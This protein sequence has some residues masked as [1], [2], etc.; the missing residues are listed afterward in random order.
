MSWLSSATGI[1]ISPHGVKIEPLKALGTALTV[2]SLGGLGGI[3]AALGKVPGLARVGGAIGTAAK[4]IPGAQAATG[5]LGGALSHVPGASQVGNTLLHG[6]GSA[7]AIGG[8]A[9]GAQQAA[10]AGSQAPSQAVFDAATEGGVEGAA[11]GAGGGSGWLGQLGNFLGKPGVLQAGADIAGGLMQGQAAAAQN[12]QQA[13][14]FNRVQ[15]FNEANNAMAMQRQQAAGP[16]RDQALF[17]LKQRM[18]A[19]QQAFI[20]HDI[21]NQSYGSGPAQLGG[22]SLQN[23]NILN[24]AQGHYQ[25]GMGGVNQALYDAYMKK[26]GSMS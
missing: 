10:G 7:G 5:A 3:G 8:G 2:G 21:Y 4:A 14:Q 13:Q 26:Y 17:M 15:G 6:F 11:Q 23:R 20:P 18:G 22:L 25:P 19:P 1:H 12:K 24:Q 9:A 16:L